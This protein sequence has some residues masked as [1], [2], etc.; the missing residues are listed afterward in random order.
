MTDLLS[1][2]ESAG[3][4]RGPFPLMS[5]DWLPNLI[6]FEN[7]GGDW[8][9]Y[10]EVLYAGYE[11]DFV[12]SKPTWPGK[13]VSLKRHREYQGKGATSW[14][15]IS[16]GSNEDERIPDFRRCERIRWPRPIMDAFPDREWA[17]GDLIFW[18]KSQRGREWRYVLAIDDFSY[19]VV[20]ADRGEYVMPWTAYHVAQSH[21]QAK[22]RREYET[23]WEGQKC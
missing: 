7:A 10:L 22:L 20:V 14:H 9:A 5:A 15:F 12:A 6:L 21:R 23:Y 11:A 13:R 2:G 4:E 18:W 3:V 16:E 17:E 19:V 1:E 8:N